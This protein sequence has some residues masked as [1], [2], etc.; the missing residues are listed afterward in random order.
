MQ[1]KLEDLSPKP[2]LNIYVPFSLAPKD[3]VLLVDKEKKYHDDFLTNLQQIDGVRYYL[4][5]ERMLSV[6]MDST[7]KFSE[8]KALVLAET[9]DFLTAEKILSQ[10]LFSLPK[11]DAGKLELIEALADSFI[12]PTLNRDKGD[13]VF[14][15]L[16]KG[17]LFL[18]FTGHCAG[19]PYAKN[20]LNGV[21]S[22]CLLKYLPFLKK[23]ETKDN[24]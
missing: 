21:V 18:K 8:V 10:E 6:F 14:C 11:D 19:C 9:D 24:E 5:T 17:D 4:V 2:L 23:I 3:K 7:A 12:R 16:E 1:F 20:T 15:G 22:G 13:I